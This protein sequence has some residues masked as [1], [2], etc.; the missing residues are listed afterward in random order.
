MSGGCCI[1]PGLAGPAIASVA[2]LYPECEPAIYRRPHAP[3]SALFSCSNVY[4]YLWPSSDAWRF[5]PMQYERAS[6][7]IPSVPY[8][9]QHMSRPAS[10]T[11]DAVVHT[12]TLQSRNKPAYR[13]RVH[14]SS[15]GSAATLTPTAIP[16]PTQ[17]ARSTACLTPE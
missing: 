3:L 13:P 4:A 9:S 16:S 14:K 8:I 2:V 12:P 11:V 5:A 6:I 1:S 17:E 15:L 10:P 7:A